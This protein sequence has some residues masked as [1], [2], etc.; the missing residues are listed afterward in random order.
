M[1]K[2]TQKLPNRVVDPSRL[3]AP[4]EPSRLAISYLNT[5]RVYHPPL[6]QLTLLLLAH[7][8]LS[9]SEL[10]D[11][12]FHSEQ[13]IFV[14]APPRSC[15]VDLVI[16]FDRVVVEQFKKRV[17]GL[18]PLLLWRSLK[19]LFKNLHLCNWACQHLRSY[20]TILLFFGLLA[21]CS[22]SQQFR[23]NEK[24]CLDIHHMDMPILKLNNFSQNVSIRAMDHRWTIA[25][26]R[27][28]LWDRMSIDGH[29]GNLLTIGERPWRLRTDT[30]LSATMSKNVRAFL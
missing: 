14:N 19:L 17:E 3:L 27:S 10:L 15:L 25:G 4:A 29:P 23:L 12:P 20:S 24:D 9:A 13:K 5:W 1:P 22:L 26:Q 18:R 16:A 28:A 8:P 21:L 30:P 6:E 11:L 2:K 7:H